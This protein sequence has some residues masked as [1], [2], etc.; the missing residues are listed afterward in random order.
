VVYFDLELIL[1]GYDAVKKRLVEINEL[2]FQASQKEKDLAGT[3]ELALEMYARG[4][5]L[6]PID[7][8]KSDATKFW[9][10][11]KKRLI[12]PFASISGIGENAAKAIV[13][14]REQGEFLSIEDFQQRTR[15]S[16]KVIEILERMGCFKGLPETNQLALF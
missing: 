15:V 7:L 4:I 10:D 1:N 14:A 8:Y 6:L 12:P 16:K 2:G 13:E 9:L 3:L 5:E 11:E